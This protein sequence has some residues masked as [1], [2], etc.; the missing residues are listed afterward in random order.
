LNAIRTKIVLTPAKKLASE[1]QIG[2]RFFPPENMTTFRVLT[3]TRWETLPAV[4]IHS[5]IAILKRLDRWSRDGPALRALNKH[6]CTAIDASIV[7]AH[8]KPVV[9]EFMQPSDSKSLKKFPNLTSVDLMSFWLAGMAPPLNYKKTR[10]WWKKLPAPLLRERF[11]NL[12]DELANLP[13]LSELCIDDCAVWESNNLADNPIVM[14]K[15]ANL[16][17]VHT[18]LVNG[19][20]SRGFIR[21]KQLIEILSPLPLKKINGLLS[22]PRSDEVL[23]MFP[24][25]KEVGLNV[26][27]SDD[28]L[29]SLAQSL[30]SIVINA[31]DLVTLS[32]LEGLPQ[33]V[34]LHF[35]INF[36]KD[37]PLLCRLTQL[38]HLFLSQMDE[39][40]DGYYESLANVLPSVAELKLETLQ[41]SNGF[42]ESRDIIGVEVLNKM[43]LLRCLSISYVSIKAA[44]LLRCLPSLEV[45]EIAGCRILDGFDFWQCIDNTE[46]VEGKALQR[47][48]ALSISDVWDASVLESVAKLSKIK[49]FNLEYY[50]YS[51]RKR[52]TYCLSALEKLCAAKS[53]KKLGILRDWDIVLPKEIHNLELFNRLDHLVIQSVVFP[54]HLL[55][56]FDEIRKRMPWLDLQVRV[57]YSSH[58]SFFTKEHFA[59]LVY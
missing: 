49:A 17:G 33:L 7:R 57:K 37:L 34:G 32:S 5:L 45:L 39:R 44:D 53:L 2:T 27:A 16:K 51:Q 22:M 50:P 43:S 35:N 42:G 55:E 26:G 48:V 52:N 36:C 58:E 8:P 30:E 41:I 1:L 6:W 54:E 3:V 15:M 21:N 4:A 29:T 56:A 9:V 11:L 47:I 38:R 31:L 46:T 23:K 19:P 24:R 12:L 20:V 18:V 10:R 40:E 14:E 28:G 25:L 59:G 13:K